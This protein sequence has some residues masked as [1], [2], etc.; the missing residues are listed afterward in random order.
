MAVVGES[1]INLAT[2]IGEVLNSA[3]GSVDVNNPVSYFNSESINKWAKYKPIAY[4]QDYFT[5]KSDYLTIAKTL[6]YGF[7]LD[8]IN[9]TDGI[10]SDYFTKVV[11]NYI[12]PTGGASEPYRLG[13]FRG[14]DSEATPIVAT[15]WVKGETVKINMWMTGSLAVVNVGINTTDNE[16]SI[17]FD[18]FAETGTIDLSR[19]YLYVRFYTNVGDSTDTSSYTDW[20]LKRSAKRDTGEFVG[21]GYTSV[22][23]DVSELG[24]SGSKGVLVASLLDGYSG[25]FLMPFDDN[26]Y[27]MTYVEG[28]LEPYRDISVNG[29]ALDKYAVGSWNTGI[30]SGT[31]Y[32][33]SDSASSAY[34]LRI[35]FGTVNS[36]YNFYLGSG[37][38][39][40]FRILDASTGLYYTASLVD[41]N[42]DSL[43]SQYIAYDQSNI[44][45]YLKFPGLGS[46]GGVFWGGELQVS[47]DSGVNWVTADYFSAN[48]TW[49]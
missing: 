22:S 16:T 6:N 5:S 25:E 8:T 32:P 35:F 3:G 18:D 12:A 39:T 19:T 42:R 2:E 34:Y 14:Y 46:V 29:F 31:P 33:D 37:Q 45:A 11:W 44:Y 48:I 17:T 10:L 13:D 41:V 9:V 23:I 49:T 15:E 24:I 7:D 47:H 28:A 20:V 36:E 27:F 4:A 40:Q 43:S 30:G 1:N 38:A 21:L 26:H